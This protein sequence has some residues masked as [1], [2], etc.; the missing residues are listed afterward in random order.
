MNILQKALLN[1]IVFHDGPEYTYAS[2]CGWVMLE[3]F[4]LGLLIPFN[5]FYF[6]P[7]DVSPW[8]ELKST[9]STF[10]PTGISFT[11][12][13]EK[14]RE[15][16]HQVYR[17]FQIIWASLTIFFFIDR[18]PRIML[19]FINFQES[20]VSFWKRDLLLRIS[21]FLNSINFNWQT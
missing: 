5:I 16:E 10:L 18:K 11:L 21:W 2:G 4:E 15:H 9:K 20:S 3:I 12:Y 7:P 6:N 14:W 13:C 19:K 8:L 17:D 1:S